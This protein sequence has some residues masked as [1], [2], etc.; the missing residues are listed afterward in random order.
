MKEIVQVL[1][2][3]T[4]LKQVESTTIGF[5]DGIDDDDSDG[6]FERFTT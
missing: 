3:H 6:E 2:H 4:I 5:N 1:K